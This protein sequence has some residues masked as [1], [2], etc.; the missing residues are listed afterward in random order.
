MDDGFD[1]PAGDA[2][3]AEVDGVLYE[4]NVDV[5]GKLEVDFYPD[6]DQERLALTFLVGTRLGSYFIAAP[7]EVPE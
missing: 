7:R 3:L 6:P 2:P 5:A 1:E 4:P